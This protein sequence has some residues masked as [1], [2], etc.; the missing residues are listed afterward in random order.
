MPQQLGQTAA[1]SAT[2]DL[3]GA[4]IPPPPHWRARLCRCPCWTLE[5]LSGRVALLF[6]LLFLG[7]GES[8]RTRGGGKERRIAISGRKRRVSLPKKIA[9]NSDA[10]ADAVGRDPSQ[11][12]P[13]LS[14]VA[15]AQLF[16]TF[17]RNNF[18]GS[19]NLLLPH[20][21]PTLSTLDR[22]ILINRYF[23][24]LLSEIE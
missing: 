11:V 22:S 13:N 19:K 20:A 10:T 3:A 17:A 7:G 8:R 24:Y 1:E 9:Q 15:P 5:H 21:S 16:R 18:A 6:L 14:V 23:T 12:C 4:A 2:A